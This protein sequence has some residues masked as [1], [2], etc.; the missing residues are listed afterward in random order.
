MTRPSENPDPRGSQA[1]AC[2]LDHSVVQQSELVIPI[3]D[4][5]KDISVPNARNA[6]FSRKNVDC[7]MNSTDKSVLLSN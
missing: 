6:D 1:G 7:Q 2:T 3:P 4:S 5:S